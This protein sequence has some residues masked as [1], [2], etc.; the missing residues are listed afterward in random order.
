MHDWNNSVLLK[1]SCHEGKCE[2]K[3]KAIW[4]T[5]LCDNLWD[6]GSSSTPFNIEHKLTAARRNVP[7]WILFFSCF[8]LFLLLHTSILVQK[9]ASVY[10]NHIPSFISF[11]FTHWHW[12]DL[13]CTL[14]G[15]SLRWFKP[16]M[17][18]SRKG[19]APSMLCVLDTNSL[20]LFAC[21]FQ[22]A[23]YQDGSNLMRFMSCYKSPKEK[24]L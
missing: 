20:K 2:T 24:T 14:S 16:L 6:P 21:I 8:T 18:P 4:E 19:T 3:S 10:T 15:P 12:W 9:Q 7:I 13:F 5:G 23:K 22:G 11:C 1:Q 17:S